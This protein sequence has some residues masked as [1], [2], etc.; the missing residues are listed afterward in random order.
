ML[1]SGCCPAPICQGL[2]RG[3]W[4][5]A[6]NPSLLKTSLKTGISAPTA[7]SLRTVIYEAMADCAWLSHLHCDKYDFSFQMIN[8]WKQ[9]LLSIVEIKPYTTEYIHIYSHISF[10]QIYKSFWKT[11]ISAPSNLESTA[12]PAP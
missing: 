12:A 5:C 7:D 2:C 3:C 11:D 6:L 4:L 8:L 10:Y 1:L 9:E